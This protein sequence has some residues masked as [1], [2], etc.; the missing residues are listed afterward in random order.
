M[1][2]SNVKKQPEQVFPSVL[3]FKIDSETPAYRQ[4]TT[5]LRDLITSHALPAGL[6]LPT[7]KSLAKAWNTNYFTAQTG[8]SPLINE[9]LLES[10]P[11]RGTFVAGNAKRI[12]AI[13][14]YYGGN[15]WTQTDGAF[16]QALY[17]ALCKELAEREIDV[18][19]FIDS[20]PDTAQSVPFKPLQE[21]IKNSAVNAVIGLA[22][23]SDNCTWMENLELPFCVFSSRGHARSVCVDIR[24]LVQASLKRLAA[25][26]CR[27][28]GLI[29]VDSATE[30][31]DKH[32]LKYAGQLGLTVSK[33]WIRLMPRGTAP[34]EEFGFEQFKEVWSQQDRPDG[35]LVYPDTI[36]RGVM[37]MVLGKGVRVPEDLRLVM[38]RVEETPFYCPLPVDWQLLST[39]TTAKVLIDHVQAQI[40]GNAPKRV[41]IKTAWK[42]AV[43]ARG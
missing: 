24:H 7:L 29:T 17:V 43:T 22:L 39:L 32:F 8:V 31:I 1:S 11:G 33:A 4:I 25:E 13:G 34:R 14:V 40:A 41:Q 42:S 37:T 28:V 19:L 9:G 27:K 15:F 30:N 16:Y 35:I 23:N 5:T 20:R 21:A 38:H 2:R 6:R 26:G 3:K 10:S 18:R 36:G 12:K